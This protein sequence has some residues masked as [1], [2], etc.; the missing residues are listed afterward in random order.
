MARSRGLGDVYKRQPLD[1]T[2]IPITKPLSP[3]VLA[4]LMELL[5]IL[6]IPIHFLP[7]LPKV[8]FGKPKIM[9]NLGCN[10]GVLGR[11]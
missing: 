10:S 6:P 8:E 3:Q 1:R 5:F 4:E 9:G 7:W 2:N 11:A